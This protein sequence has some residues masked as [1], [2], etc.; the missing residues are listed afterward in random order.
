[1]K[2]VVKLTISLPADLAEF[3]DRLAERVRRPRSQVFA[4]LVAEKQRQ[5]LRET[6]AEG[7]QAISQDN[8]RFAREAALIAAEVWDVGDDRA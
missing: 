6:L 2:R 8:A 1:M 3:M 7:Y 5:T 4:E